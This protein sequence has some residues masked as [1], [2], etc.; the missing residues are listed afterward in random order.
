M[1]KKATSKSAAG[2]KAAQSARRRQADQQRRRLEGRN[3]RALIKL[4]Q[5]P[6]VAESSRSRRRPRSL[7]SPSMAS[8][9][10]AAEAAASA[11]ARPSRKPA[12]PPRR[13]LD[14]ASAMNS[15]KFGRR[16]RLRAAQKRKLCAA[17]DAASRD[18][19]SPGST[20]SPRAVSTL[21]QPP[22]REPCGLGDGWTAAAPVA[23]PRRAYRRVSGRGARIAG[24]ASAEPLKD[25]YAL[26]RRACRHFAGSPRPRASFSTK[27]ADAA[28]RDSASKAQC[29]AP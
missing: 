1:A 14:G 15:T 19:T 10:A 11:P 24:S 9:A 8:P 13:R 21:I 28:P 23:R 26:L 2:P 17:D 27:V 6:L 7:H 4:M 5:S 29:P 18:G 12:R 3:G 22:G 20:A 25:A 16:R